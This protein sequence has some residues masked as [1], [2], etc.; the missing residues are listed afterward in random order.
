MTDTF[1]EGNLNC[2]SQSLYFKNELY[3]FDVY[4]DL[5]HI[6]FPLS[7]Y[8]FICPKYLLND[9]RMLEVLEMWRYTKIP[10][11]F[12]LECSRE[13]REPINQSSISLHWQFSW[14][15]TK[16]TQV[17]EYNERPVKWSFKEASVFISC[18]PSFYKK[19]NYFKFYI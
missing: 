3:I 5:I 18:I 2:L 19:Q 9:F 6:L 1:I 17:N 15:K 14:T 11:H 16:Q 7:S 4:A 13:N 12:W 8:S 10:T